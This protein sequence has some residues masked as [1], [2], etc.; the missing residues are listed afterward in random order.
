MAGMF[1]EESGVEQMGFCFQFFYFNF[2]NQ[3]YN[4][5]VFVL[6]VW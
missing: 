1:V 6:V 5:E 4:N 2:F 3:K